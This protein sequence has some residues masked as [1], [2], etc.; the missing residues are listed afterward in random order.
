MSDDDDDEK[1]YF[2]VEDAN[3]SV[4]ELSALFARVMQLRAQL[5]TLYQSLDEAGHAPGDEELQGT[6]ESADNLPD[7]APSTVQ[8]DYV[9]FRALMSTLR[10]QVE[11]IQHTGAII[12]DIEIGLVDWP[13][14]HQGR[15][16]WLCWKY[17]ES[18]VSHWHEIH[19]GFSAR[20]PVSELEPSKTP[21]A[22]S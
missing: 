2:T 13:A 17:G 18:E 14:M 8:R 15:E 10:E 5:K 21:A 1:L 7:D 20:R 6:I 11:D 3:G 4:S 22:G 19:T 16:V 12:K 9:R